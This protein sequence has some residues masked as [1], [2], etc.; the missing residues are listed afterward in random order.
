MPEISDNS[1]CL[2]AIRGQIPNA[3]TEIIGRI[4]YNGGQV[5]IVGGAIRHILLNLPIKDWDLATS[6]H[7]DV[8]ESIF[9]D[10]TTVLTGRKFG[11]ITVI[12]DNM[13]VEITTFRTEENYTDLRHPDKITY[14]SDIYKDLSRRDFTI[15]A[16]A[17]N[18]YLS[19]PLVDPFGG[20]GDLA[21]GIIKTVGNAHER[22]SEDPLRVIRCV[23][24]LSELGFVVCEQT[25]DAVCQFAPLLAQIPRE[26]IR[27]EFSRIL[28]AP[29]VS[30]G[31]S[32]LTKTGILKIILPDLSITYENCASSISKSISLC[33]SDLTLRL[34]MLFYHIRHSRQ[35]VEHSM[36]SLKY[37]NYTIKA[38][39]KILSSSNLT[40][41]NDHE[42][43]KYHLRKILNDIG[44]EDAHRVLELIFA[45]V[46]SGSPVYSSAPDAQTDKSQNGMSLEN[47]EKGRLYLMEV[48]NDPVKLSDLAINGHDLLNAG[49]GTNNGIELGKTLKRA[50]DLVHRNPEWN[51]KELLLAMLKDT[52]L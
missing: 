16:I 37:D 27:E 19:E 48:L 49:I 41:L 28:L 44:S 20:R 25:Y 1:L 15:N 34:A 2:S 18:P 6:L 8:I 7:P 11:T 32:M 47:I 42:N 14:V 50:L 21:Q 13:P 3:I 46:I 12:S 36:K 29:R 51:K 39:L 26:R 35:T 10:M 31:L 5:Y 9:S 24:F 4:M 43:F 30:D 38:V 17:Y 23:R 52:Q 22:F 45:F 33:G 40:W